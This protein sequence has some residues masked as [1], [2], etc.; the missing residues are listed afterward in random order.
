MTYII[1]YAEFLLAGQTLRDNPEM[2]EATFMAAMAAANPQ[3]LTPEEIAT[4]ISQATQPLLDLGLT[5]DTSFSAYAQWVRSLLPQNVSKTIKMV[6]DQYLKNMQPFI[7]DN[8]LE[9]NV[10]DTAIVQAKADL[11]QQKIIGEQEQEWLDI[12]YECQAQ[13]NNQLENFAKKK[14]ILE[15]KRAKYP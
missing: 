7:L 15:F 11:V 5:Q 2:D 4:T 10:A 9:K 3:N 14:A 13:M 1:S 8:A 6:H 12:L